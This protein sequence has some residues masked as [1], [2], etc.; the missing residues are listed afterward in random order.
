[1]SRG[2]LWKALLALSLGA[3]IALGAV[4]LFH[5]RGDPEGASPET[6]APSVPCLLASLGLDPA[7]R[8][9]VDR[10]RSEFE[11][12]HEGRHEAVRAAREK[13]FVAIERMAG[14]RTE[15]DARLA[16]LAGAQL[17]M[18]RGLVDHVLSILAVLG[19]GERARFLE[20][21]RSRFIQGPHHGGHPA[22]E[23]RCGAVS[24]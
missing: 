14:E 16:E 15:V 10:I 20:G 4:I 23:E 24:Q 19:P 5:G 17:A 8:A 9:E 18:R 1:M 6:S 13:L 12:A 11:A 21:I 22:T 2:L 3:N 7:R